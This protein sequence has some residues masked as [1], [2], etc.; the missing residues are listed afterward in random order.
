MPKFAGAGCELLDGR[1]AQRAVPTRF[2]DGK[3]FANQWVMA[4]VAAH[5]ADTDVMSC[6]HK[7]RPSGEETQGMEPFAAQRQTTWQARSGFGAND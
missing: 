5:F 6:S 3:I 2:A 1:T 7:W 4:Q